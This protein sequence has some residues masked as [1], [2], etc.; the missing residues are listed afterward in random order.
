[1]EL[2]VAGHLSRDLVITPE[3]TR[4][5]IGGGTAYAMIAMALEAFGAGIVTCVGSDFEE[6]YMQVLRDSGLDLDGLVE[7]GSKSTRFINEYD[8]SGTRTQKVEAIAPPLQLDDLRP[9]H[10]G[11][12]IYHFCPLTSDEIPVSMIEAAR[13]SGG[14]ISLDAQGYLRAAKGKKVVQKE[15]DGRDD[16][17]RLVDV[18]KL[19]ESELAT[20]VDAK[21]ELSAATELLSLGPRMILVTRQ[22][23]GSTIYTRNIQVDIPLVLANAQVDSTG[24]GDTYAIGFLLEYMRTGDV[25]RAGLFGATCSSFNVE[26]AGPYDMPTR[27]QVERRMK[28]YAQA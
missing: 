9:K 4:E 22:Q 26:T 15:W 24:C 5:T 25:K 1:M 27:E 16:I 18:V 2:V 14:L 3:S 12:S 21:S 10:L 28:P 11:A 13:S 20:A 8:E 6:E 19:D 7:R 23:K 17:V